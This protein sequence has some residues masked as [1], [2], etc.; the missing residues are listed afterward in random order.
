MINAISN[1]VNPAKTSLGKIDKNYEDFLKLLTTQLQNQDPAEPTDTNQLTQQIA[2]LSQVEQQLNTNKNLEKLIGMYQATQYNSVVSYIG[3]QIEADG[4]A[5]ELIS[6]KAGFVYYLGAEADKV[7]VNIKDKSGAVV[8]S[9]D[10]T[11]VAGR[12]VF[13]WDGKNNQGQTMPEGTYTI[14]L[15]AKDLQGKDVSSKTFI[16]GV[17]S[18]VD[19]IDGVAYLS[20]GDIAIPLEKVTSIR[21]APTT[22][23]AS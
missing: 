10:G 8:Y 7:T 22:A 11:K 18:S 4:N 3:K 2:T 19:S 6:G 14:Q 23:Q 12:N 21:L 1:E 17:V 16:S 15:T 9:G 20:I 13:N 5:A